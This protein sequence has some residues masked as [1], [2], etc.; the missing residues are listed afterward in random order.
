MRIPEVCLLLALFS[1]TV[2][3]ET[4][5]TP[6]TS[7]KSDSTAA[8]IDVAK[9]KFR[10]DGVEILTETQGVDFGPWIE[11]WHQETEKTWKSLTPNEVN[12][13]KLLTGMVMI[14]F[15]VLP[16]GRLKEGSMVLE[17]RSGNTALDKAAWGALTGSNY[18]PLPRDFTGPFLELR[19]RFLYNMEPGH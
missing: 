18:P 13:P 2:S 9:E 3:G 19:T 10:P 4:L 11:L 6:A 16:N 5:T 12:P 7:P 14:R 17:G 15:K 1:A 8:K